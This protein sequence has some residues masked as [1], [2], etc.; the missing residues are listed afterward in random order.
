MAPLVFVL[1]YALLTILM[2]P[3][4]LLTAAGGLLFGSAW[5]T[6][7]AML[8]A[9]AGAAGAFLLGRRLGRE[10]VTRLASGRIETLDRWLTRQGFVAV[11]YARLIS[12]IPFNV[13]N[14][15]AGVTGVRFR[16]YLVATVPGIVPGAFAYAAPGGS[17]R[18]PLSPVFL[19]PIGMV[20]LLVVA[21]PLVNRWLRARGRLPAELADEARVGPGP[22]PPGRQ[23]SA[24]KTA[25]PVTP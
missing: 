3:G 25:A 1:A 17:F 24:R 20:V 13:L 18:D 4:S 21:G 22:A 16:D 12:V 23:C 5:G 15:G 8:G 2:F 10:Q 6:V 19:T 7:L 11:L 9:S 14:Y